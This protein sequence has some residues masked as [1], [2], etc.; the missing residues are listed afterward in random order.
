LK[1][2][3]EARDLKRRKARERNDLFVVEGI[4]ATE[5]LLRS[6]LRV[7]G[8]LVSPNLTTGERG[9][10]L[11]E[12]LRGSV[13]E[14][15]EVDERALQ[16]AAN[17]DT[18]QGVVVIAEIPDRKLT[19]IKVSERTRLLLLDA[20]Q[21]PG[22][23]GTMLRT[24]AAFGV[25]ATIALP[26][27]VDL[28]SAKVVRSA[29]GTQFNHFALHSD[30]DAIWG[31]LEREGI[32]LWGSESGAGDVR[33]LDTIPARLALAVGNEG[34]GLTEDL[35][36]RMQRSVGVPT[37]SEVESLNVAVAAG[38]LLYEICR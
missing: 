6:A 11:L 38:I 14:V 37:S 17:T 35:R 15:L 2:L 27:T 34:S 12:Q 24:A 10:R 31:L 32:T 20:V 33:T 28:W 19:D 16:T 18:P 13:P 7:R 1:L 4:R 23:A 21:D 9:H 25:A 26:G 36:A 5:E 8:A 3:S 29:M 22:N 30:S